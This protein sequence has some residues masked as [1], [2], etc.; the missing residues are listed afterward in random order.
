MSLD[1]NSRRPAPSTSA[2]PAHLRDLPWYPASAVGAC[3]DSSL[4]HQSRA[5]PDRVG[6]TNDESHTLPPLSFESLTTIKFSNPLVLKTIRN[7]GG[8]TYPLPPTPFKK[9]FSSLQILNASASSTFVLCIRRRRVRR[10]LLFCFNFEL[11]TFNFG[12]LQVLYMQ[13][14]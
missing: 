5:C 1:Q 7:A 12:A 11:S 4:L 6:V 3:G 8:C 10:F 9:H 13:H 14:L 2:V